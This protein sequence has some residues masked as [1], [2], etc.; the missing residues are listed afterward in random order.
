MR[1][2]AIIVGPLIAFIAS[3]APPDRSSRVVH[4]SSRQF[5]VGGPVLAPSF[6]NSPATNSPLV[7][8]DAKILAVSCERIKQALLRE[9][10]MVDLWRGRI[11][12]D[13]NPLMIDNQPPIV[14]AKVFT[15]GWQYR[16]EVPR[17]IE[18]LK[19]VRG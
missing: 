2:L 4:S 7:E 10:V 14:A 5:T 19:L 16:L 11:Y 13:I 17:Q 15:D 8:L 9:L 12:V 1:I 3:A 18:K 6:T